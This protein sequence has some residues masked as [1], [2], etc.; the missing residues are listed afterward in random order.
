MT[1][2]QSQ[3]IMAT[4]EDAAGVQAT[5]DATGLVLDIGQTTVKGDVADSPLG[6]RIYPNEQAAWENLASKS[7]GQSMK[8]VPVE[9]ELLP[10]PPTKPRK[11]KAAAKR[12]PATRKK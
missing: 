3:P 7:L 9:D 8:L 12:K 6:I 1:I 10:I 4:I 2:K 11:P 5:R